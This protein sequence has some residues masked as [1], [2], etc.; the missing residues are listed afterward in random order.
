METI[1]NPPPPPQKIVEKFSRE[2]VGVGRVTLEVEY[3]ERTTVNEAQPW[4]PTQII[5]GAVVYHI[6][7]ESDGEKDVEVALSGAAMDILV[8]LFERLQQHPQVG[9]GRAR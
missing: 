8:D 3:A 5:R 9:L 2:L 6:T 1:I 4:A 7:V